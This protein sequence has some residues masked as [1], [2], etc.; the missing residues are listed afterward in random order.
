MRN[1]L[2]VALLGVALGLTAPLYAQDKAGDVTDMQA[3]RQAVKNDK[4]AL[5]A[6]MLNLSDSE[7]KRFWPIYEAYQ[8]EIDNNGRRRGVALQEMMFRDRPMTNSAARQ[9]ATE[10]LAVDEALMRARRTMRNRVMRAL[11]AVKAARYLQLEEKIRAVQDYDVAAT[12][13]LAR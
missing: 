7:A 12:V 4:R 1:A 3:L 11:P 5:V 2:A 6:S 10:L 8:R 9:Y 13:P